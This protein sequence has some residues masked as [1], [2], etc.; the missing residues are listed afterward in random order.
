MVCNKS[1]PPHQFLHIAATLFIYLSAGDS[2]CQVPAGVTDC[3]NALGSEVAWGQN[4]VVLRLYF[5]AAEGTKLILAPQS[6]L[7]DVQPARLKNK[8]CVSI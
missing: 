1:F 6:S 7:A 8:I 2:D 5:C 4:R 3:C